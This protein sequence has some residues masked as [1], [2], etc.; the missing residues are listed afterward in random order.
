MINSIGLLSKDVKITS[1]I[2]ITNANVTNSLHANFYLVHDGTL[3]I[4]LLIFYQYI[5]PNGTVP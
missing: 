2:H 1:P 5:V 4:R 3:A